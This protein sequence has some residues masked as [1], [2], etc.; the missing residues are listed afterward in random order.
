M[1]ICTYM[2][3]TDHGIKIHLLCRFED[4]DK[5]PFLTY[6]MTTQSLDPQL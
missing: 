4:V 5:P 6:Y 1:Y 3:A 2:P